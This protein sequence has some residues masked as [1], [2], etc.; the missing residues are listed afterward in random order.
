MIACVLSCLWS[1]Q[2]Q[3]SSLGLVV[4]SR[5]PKLQVSDWPHGPAIQK[6]E[7]GNVYLIEFWATW[8]PPCVS[9]APHLAELQRKY[10]S[11][12]LKVIGITQLDNWGSDP[13]SIGQLLKQMGPKMDYP[14]G[15]DE[16]APKA[17]QGVVNGRT[18]CAYLGAAQVQAIPCS[19]LV[20][21]EGRIAFIGLPTL[22]D[23]PLQ[24]V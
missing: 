18:E 13:D 21:R 12:G 24:Q 17:Y 9:S 10:E 11:K 14:I 15:I 2:A 22:V 4:G 7:P 1:C 8:C 3:A 5:A 23:T 20:D 16:V 19:F 6:L